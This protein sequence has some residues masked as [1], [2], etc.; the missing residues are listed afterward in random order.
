MM[1]SMIQEKCFKGLT[2]VSEEWFRI[3]KSKGHFLPKLAETTINGL[4]KG[5]I[6][7]PRQKNKDMQETQKENIFT[8]TNK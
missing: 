7:T 5:R 2:W 3:A 1:K 6:G 4:I 8:K